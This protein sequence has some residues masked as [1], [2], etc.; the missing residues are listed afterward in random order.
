MHKSNDGREMQYGIIYENRAHKSAVACN[1][2]MCNMYDFGTRGR[3]ISTQIIVVG[4][5]CADIVIV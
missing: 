2:C 4:W 1:I 3:I 5:L